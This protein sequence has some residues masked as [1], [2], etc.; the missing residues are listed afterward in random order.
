MRSPDIQ[1]L[2][3][4]FLEEALPLTG[5]SKTWVSFLQRA[6]LPRKPTV[7]YSLFPTPDSSWGYSDLREATSMEKRYFTSDGN[8]R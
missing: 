1:V 7:R 8:A 6:S 4:D 5:R 2:P 3:N